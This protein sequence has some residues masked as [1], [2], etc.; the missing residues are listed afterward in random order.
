MSLTKW[1]F[2]KS[3]IDLPRNGDLVEFTGTGMNSLLLDQP[4]IQ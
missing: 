2:K 4:R 1:K 3:V